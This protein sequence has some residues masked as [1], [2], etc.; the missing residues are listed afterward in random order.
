MLLIFQ[1]GGLLWLGKKEGRQ[2]GRKEGREKG[3]DQQRRDRR[4]TGLLLFRLQRQVL[5]RG[6]YLTACAIVI[7]SLPCMLK[8]VLT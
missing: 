7:I 6:N 2:G 4:K 3:G 8:M 5:R 1:W